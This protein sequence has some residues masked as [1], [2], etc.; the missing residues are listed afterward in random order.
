[1]NGNKIDV[2][3]GYINGIKGDI[4]TD[5]NGMLY[6]EMVHV[7]Q[8]YKN[9]YEKNP[10]VVEGIADFVR[11]KVGYASLHWK[12]VGKGDSWNQ[13]YDVTTKF[14]DYCES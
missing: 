9:V 8:W 13:G 1:M 7:W 6:H 14:L 4:K 5:F 2:G 3:A 12:K 11:L 10:E